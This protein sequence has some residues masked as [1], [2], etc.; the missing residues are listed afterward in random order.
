MICGYWELKQQNWALHHNRMH[1]VQFDH[2]HIFSNFLCM[3]ISR[4]CH[5]FSIPTLRDQGR[6]NWMGYCPTTFWWSCMEEGYLPTHYFLLIWVH[7]DLAHPLLNSFLCPW[8]KKY[9][10]KY[11]VILNFLWFL[12]IET[13]W[14]CLCF[15]G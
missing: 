4:W 13:I 3:N 9:Q 14:E 12:K 11:Q 1:H 2:N 8:M 15:T 10:I 6:W 7:F 5:I